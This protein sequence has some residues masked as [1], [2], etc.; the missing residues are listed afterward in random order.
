[1]KSIKWMVVGALC[2]VLVGCGNGLDKSPDLTSFEVYKIKINQD[3]SE[4]E[5]Q[6]VEAFNFAVSDVNFEQLK[7]KYP[8]TPYRKIARNELESYLASLQTQ[9]AEAQKLKPEFEK[10]YAELNKVKVE[11]LGNE[12]THDTFFDKRDLKYSFR[13]T[14]GSSIPM[15]KVQLVANFSINGKPDVL[16]QWNPVVSFDNGLRPGQTAAFS[17]SMVGFPS[18]DRPITLEVREAKSREVK[19]GVTDLADFSEQWLI[20]KNSPLDQLNSLPAK[21]EEAKKYLSNL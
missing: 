18:F 15:S 1:M 17:G 6:E 16:Y 9:L 13:L 14:N 12:L 20:G 19:L 8:G 3:F 21:I 4:A 10:R 5:P 7:Q 2:L 11:V